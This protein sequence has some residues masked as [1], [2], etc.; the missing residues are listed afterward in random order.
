MQVYMEFLP[1]WYIPFSIYPFLQSKE[2][3][4]NQVFHRHN[5]VYPVPVT[6][7]TAVPLE[8]FPW[9]K[10]SDFLATMYKMNDLNHVLGGYSL[11][12]AKPML[13]NFWK[14]YR[15]I[16]P[17]Y[18]LWEHVD[19]GRKDIARCVPLY[20]HGDEGTSFKKGGIFIFSF[21]GAVGFGTSKR[22]EHFEND[23]RAAGE[24]I[25]LNFLKTGLQTR[26]MICSCPKDCDCI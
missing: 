16:L 12:E 15:G 2:E 10:P 24:G 7:E 8:G 17:L 13:V 19:S 3:V 22:K 9:I 18:Q 21:Q 6:T 25:R 11:Q 1:L 20:L 23:L 4:V 5:F 26:M 14:K